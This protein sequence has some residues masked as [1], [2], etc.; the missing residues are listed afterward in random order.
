MRK[1]IKN[2]YVLDM[3]GD[4][5]NIRKADILVQDNKIEKIDIVI[6]ETQADEKINA[7]KKERKAKAKSAK[8]EQKSK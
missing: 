8:K 4:V 3:V 6:D 1:L 7:E 2:A 5:P